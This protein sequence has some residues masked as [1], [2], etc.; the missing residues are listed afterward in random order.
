MHRSGRKRRA[1]SSKTSPVLY[2][3]PG[4]SPRL[5]MEAPARQAAIVEEEVR[6]ELGHP[7]VY[8]GLWPTDAPPQDQSPSH[9]SWRMQELVAKLDTHSSEGKAP[10]GE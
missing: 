7:A 2:A 4:L 6:A 9:G 8:P 5:G 1:P 10:S 3:D